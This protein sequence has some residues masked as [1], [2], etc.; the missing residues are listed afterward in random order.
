M[1]K[2]GEERKKKSVGLTEPVFGTNVKKMGK[3]KIIII[4]HDT[5]ITVHCKPRDKNGEK[6]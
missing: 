3:K 6:Y 2:R 1:I 5:Y 4:K